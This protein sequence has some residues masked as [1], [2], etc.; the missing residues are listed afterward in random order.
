MP[1]LDSDGY[2]LFGANDGYYG[3][4]IIF[5]LPDT[6]ATSWVHSYPDLPP[7]RYYVHVGGYDSSCGTCPIREWST[8]WTR[9]SPLAASSFIEGS[10]DPGTCHRDKRH[11]S[12]S[13]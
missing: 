10:S 13:T 12:P 5:E 3:P 8:S 4:N 6:A 9:R 7:G 1:A 11:A 2:F